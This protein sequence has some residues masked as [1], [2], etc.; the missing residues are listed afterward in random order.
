MHGDA[1]G[2]RTGASCN[3]RH[4]E[5]FFATRRQETVQQPARRPK[6]ARGRAPQRSGSYGPRL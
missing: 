3:R 1:A 4:Q 6:P 5:M 2:L